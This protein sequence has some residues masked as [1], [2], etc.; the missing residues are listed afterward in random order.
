MGCCVT[1]TAYFQRGFLMKKILI[2]KMSSIGDVVHSLPF[3]EVIKA[4]YPSARI[5]WLV[6]EAASQILVGHPAI[7]R[8]IISRRKSWQRKL[9]SIK[10]LLSVADEASQFYRNLR[11]VEYDLVVDL[12][13]LFRSGLLVGMTRARRKIGMVGA[14]E[15]AGFFLNEIPVP[16]K[17][18]QHAVDR[19]LQVGQYLGC[20]VTG[21]KGSIPVSAQDQERVNILLRRSIDKSRAIVAINPTARWQTKIWEPDRL[22]ALA[23]RIQNELACDIVFTGSA[24]DRSI[25][26]KILRSMDNPPLNLSGKTGLKDLACLFA[27][28][29]LLITADTGPMHIAAAMGCPVLAIFGPTD[30]LRTGPY[31]TGHCVL[32]AGVACSPCFKRR[33]RSMICMKEISVDWCWVTVKD[34]LQGNHGHS[35]N[36]SSKI[37]N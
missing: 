25:I 12:Q 8:L 13:G 15:G 21:W 27:M 32:R 33:C 14:R 20:D 23:N 7:N 28:S 31:G 9:F 2:V 3:L 34:M 10:G 17:Y 19:Y 16:V 18:A 24:R 37:Q 30:P 6:E 26:D 22:A 29:R 11:T 1:N 36:G 5:D 4:K 35:V